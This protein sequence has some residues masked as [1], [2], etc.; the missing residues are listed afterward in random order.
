MMNLIIFLGLI[1]PILKNDMK[2]EINSKKFDVHLEESI[3]T[4]SFVDKLPIKINM[5]DLNANEKYYYLDFSLKTEPVK[6][7]R[8][9]AGDI[10]LFGDNCIVIFY[11]SFNTSY[12]YTKIGSIINPQNLEETLGRSD[13]TV[14][15]K[16]D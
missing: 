1:F 7:N 11:K 2:L 15:F 9:N 6:V 8:I 14:S 13:V 4:K 12:S 10:M 3:T 16:Y 5:K